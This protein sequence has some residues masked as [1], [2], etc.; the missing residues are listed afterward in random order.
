[1]KKFNDYMEEHIVPIAGKIGSEKHLVALR[2]SFIGVMPITMAGSVA[3]LMNAFI[4][5]LPT[6]WAKDALENGNE[7][8]SETYFTFVDAM[9]PFININGIVWWATI[10]VLALVIS[11][12]VGFNFA[13]IYNV[14]PLAGG[15]TTFSAYITTIPQSINIDV[16][17][18]DL[19][20]NPVTSISA[21]GNFN[22]SYTQVAA[23]FTSLLVSIFCGMIY[24]KLMQK[25]III[26]MPE[27]VPPAVSHAFASIIPSIIAINIAAIISYL[28]SVLG[29]GIS[30]NDLISSYIQQPLLNM[31]QGLFSVI[32]FALLVQ[33]FW[34]FGLHG[35]N[36]LGPV[37]DTIYKPALYANLEYFQTH[38][39]TEGM[40]YIWTR[41]SFDAYSWMGGA[42][43]SFALVIALLIFSKKQEERTVAKLGAT[44][45]IFNINEPIIFG[46]PLV[47]NTV[48]VIPFV[49]IPTILVIIGYVA[50]YVGLIPPV[51]IEVTWVMPPIIC[52][53]LATGGNLMASLVAL[54]NLVLGVILWSPFVILANKIQI[55][56]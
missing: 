22:W 10:A 17:Y 53:F 33:I 56:E 24:I 43:C 42:G 32:I 16:N 36:V 48:Y 7:S 52:A 46:L 26:T 49:C 2:D 14:S 30:I 3:V 12:S 5:D 45:G 19:E 23:L 31:S 38:G 34:F 29:D 27:S 9:Q 18:V 37:L 20:G 55:D 8:L 39:T 1:M 40:P 6:Q 51:F 15:I 47:L 54:I 11:F 13:K 50:T 41:G 25:K 44:M 28:V 4:R 35:T 21:W